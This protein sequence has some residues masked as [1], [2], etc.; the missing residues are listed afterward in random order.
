MNDLR[1]TP[2]SEPVLLES[3]LLT[4]VGHGVKN[5]SDG[6]AEPTR[7]RDRDATFGGNEIGS[8]VPT[9]VQRIGDPSDD[10]DAFACGQ[11]A[12]IRAVERAASCGHSL[13]YFSR[14]RHRDPAYYFLGRRIDHIRQRLA[15][16]VPAPAH[17]D[18]ITC[19]QWM[20]RHANMVYF[21]R[22]EHY[23]SLWASANFVKLDHPIRWAVK[24][25][26]A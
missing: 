12:P 13:V 25:Q 24:H 26:T 6:A 14:S 19:D 8:L 17:V 21:Y 23:R 10:G 3:K 5:R 16:C 4:D 9:R 20:Y 2:V 1:R 18:S 7:S 11:P 22:D 15:A